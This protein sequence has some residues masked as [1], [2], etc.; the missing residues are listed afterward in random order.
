MKHIFFVLFI[1]SIIIFSA[2][3]SKNNN[4]SDIVPVDS[5][6]SFSVLGFCVTAPDNS[7]NVKYAIVN[8]T[9]AEVNF[10][11]MNDNYYY[12]AARNLDELL[13][14]YEYINDD[15]KIISDEETGIKIT[16][17]RNS[18]NNSIAF[19]N[20]NNINYSLYSDNKDDNIE[21]LSLELMKS[22]AIK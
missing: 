4:K 10:D 9:V 7:L 2:S 18:E 6:K 11:Y 17:K 16:I 12:R 1:F 19:W 8:K 14:F 5:P 21:A 13:S 3:C 15:D 20:V 22:K